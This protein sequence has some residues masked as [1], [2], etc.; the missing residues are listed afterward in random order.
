M[1][2]LDDVDNVNELKRYLMNLAFDSVPVVHRLDTYN[3]L[4]QIG[5]LIRRISF[6]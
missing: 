2:Q 5:L 6:P 3:N 1:V 4:N